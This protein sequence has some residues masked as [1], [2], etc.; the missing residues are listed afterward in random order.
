M[1]I[2]ARNI[3]LDI[4]VSDRDDLLHFISDQCKSFGYT[5][6][7]KGLYESFI[8]REA[9]YSTG[10]Q[11]GFAIPHAKT[12]FVKSAQIVYV[13]LNHPIEWKTYDDKPVTDIF[14][15]MVPESGVGTVHLKM[16]SNLATA[17]LEDDFKKKIRE[18]NDS[19]K[20]SEYITN[21]IG[22]NV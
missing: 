13:R 21:E 2:P 4:N 15:L 16:L 7:A 18:L 8:Q 22:V 12:D 6:S 1:E 14:A 9:E 19:E 10:L 20:I 3:L 17:L 5:D 11:E